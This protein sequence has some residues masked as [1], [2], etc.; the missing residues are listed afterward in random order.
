M[1]TYMYI[2]IYIYIIK[3]LKVAPVA[4]K[5]VVFQRTPCW[6]SPRNDRP[7]PL[8]MALAIKSEPSYIQEANRV[9]NIGI[10][11]FNR[12]SARMSFVF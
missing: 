9:Q 12:M 10:D 7:T 2:Y 5:L 6:C 4:K 11:T 8:D 3:C 1:Y